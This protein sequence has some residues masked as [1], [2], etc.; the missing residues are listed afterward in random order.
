MKDFKESYQS[1]FEIVCRC[2]GDNWRINL[3]TNDCYR[4]RITSNMFIGFSLQVREEKNR[5]SIMGSFDSRIHRGNIY[6]CTV[7]KDR[8]PVHIAEDIKRKIILFAQDEISKGKNSEKKN[9]DLKEHD[10]IVK[11]MLSQLL[12][13]QSNPH[14]GVLGGFRSENGLDGIIRTN[15]GGYKIEIGGLS[16]DSL[17]KIAGFIKQL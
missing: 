10:R 15:S 2:L 5:F 1:V 16:V 12:T 9:Q 17:I 8:N 13:L 11:G 4:I 6:S 3:L 14:C 7:S